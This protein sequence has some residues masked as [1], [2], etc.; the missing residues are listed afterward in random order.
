MTT[1]KIEQYKKK[2]EDAQK[3]LADMPNNSRTKAQY[4]NLISKIEE[5]QDLEN[6]KVIIGET[7]TSV[8][9]VLKLAAESVKTPKDVKEKRKN[10]NKVI[11]DN[12]NKI[13]VELGV[14]QDANEGYD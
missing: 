1:S 6:V 7:E 4:V 10:L 5:R 12:K 14:I 13:L 11:H 3:E 8:L 9:E 2:I